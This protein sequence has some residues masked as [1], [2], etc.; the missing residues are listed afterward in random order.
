MIVPSAAPVSRV[1]STTPPD[2]RT[3]NPREAPRARVRSSRCDTEAMLGSASPRNPS[4][5][6]ATRSSTRRILLV[7]CRSRASRASSAVI[8]SPSSSTRTRRFP[9]SSTV[10]ATRDA[11]ASRAFSTSSLATDAGRSTTSPAAIWFAS[12]SGSRTMR[13]RPSSDGGRPVMSAG[14]RRAPGL[15]P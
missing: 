13:G 3:S 4:E 6:M 8:P 12:S 1:D 11:P 2:T 14:R 15:P 9:P 5:V 10:T 7:A